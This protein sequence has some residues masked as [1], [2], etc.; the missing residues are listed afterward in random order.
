MKTILLVTLLVFASLFGAPVVE[1][2]FIGKCYKKWAD[3]SGWNRWGK[4]GFSET[5]QDDCR[6]LGKTVGN[7]VPSPHNCALDTHGFQC[8][9]LDL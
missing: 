8:Q 3:C 2:L 4:W 7:C 1:S 5:C 9:C 6:A